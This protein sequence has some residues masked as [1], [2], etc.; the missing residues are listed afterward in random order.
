MHRDP[1]ECMEHHWTG[2]ILVCNRIF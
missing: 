2:W 1:A